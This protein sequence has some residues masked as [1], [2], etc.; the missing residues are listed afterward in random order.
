MA[1]RMRPG[2]ELVLAKD[3]AGKIFYHYQRPVNAPSIRGPIIPWLNDEQ[4][5]HFLRLGLVE[6]I[7]EADAPAAQQPPF[8]DGSDVPDATLVDECVESLNRLGVALDAGAPTCRTA[9]RGSGQSWGNDTIAAAVRER[10]ARAA[11]TAS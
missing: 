11:V 8:A 7:T 9:L 2:V 6:E 3:E 4:R 1:Y 10:K 5:E